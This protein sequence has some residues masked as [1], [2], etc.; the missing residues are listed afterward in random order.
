MKAS[1]L[2]PAAIAFAI[3]VPDEW[4]PCWIVEKYLRSP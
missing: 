1:G 3:V 2:S 4:Q